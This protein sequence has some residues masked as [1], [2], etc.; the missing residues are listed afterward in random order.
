MAGANLVDELGN[1]LG[2]EHVVVVIVP[3]DLGRATR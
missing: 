2:D 1:D 3:L